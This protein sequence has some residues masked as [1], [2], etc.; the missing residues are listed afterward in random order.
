[1]QLVNIVPRY[2]LGIID[3]PIIFINIMLDGFLP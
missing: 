1:M 2:E 3:L